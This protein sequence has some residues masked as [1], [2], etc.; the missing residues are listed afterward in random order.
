MWVGGFGGR[1]RQWRKE[2]VSV[3]ERESHAGTQDATDLELCL[4]ASPTL[5]QQQW[6]WTGM[7]V[8][9]ACPP[10]QLGHIMSGG[11]KRRGR[12]EGG[13]GSWPHPLSG[14]STHKHW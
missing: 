14:T 9:P 12:G 10:A 5:A 7:Y 8:C 6:Q 4:A 11:G 13:G 3:R 2:I 1:G